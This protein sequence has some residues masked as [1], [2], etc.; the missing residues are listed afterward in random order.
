MDSLFQSLFFG[1][2]NKLFTDCGPEFAATLCTPIFRSQGFLIRTAIQKGVDQKT[3]TSE[4]DEQHAK[5][6]LI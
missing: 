6:V 5:T 4:D 3:L 2:Q 1:I